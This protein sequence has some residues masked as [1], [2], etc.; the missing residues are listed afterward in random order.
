MQSSYFSVFITVRKDKTCQ[1]FTV[2]LTSQLFTAVALVFMTTFRK[3]EDRV[4]S[5]TVF[6][7]DI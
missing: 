2:V 7:G 3:Y 4:S 5:D 1:Y 6:I